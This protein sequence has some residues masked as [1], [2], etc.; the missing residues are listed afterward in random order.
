VFFVYF[1]MDVYVQVLCVGLG[2]H[3]IYIK[4]VLTCE[5]NFYAHVTDLFFM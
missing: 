2:S 3:P 1:A 5:G 4:T